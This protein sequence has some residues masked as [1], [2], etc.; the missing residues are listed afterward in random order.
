MAYALLILPLSLSELYHYRLP[1]E[2]D[3]SRVRP[4]MRVVAPLGPKRFYTAVVHSLVDSL[5]EGIQPSRLKEIESVLDES[6]LLSQE[7]LSMWDWLATYYQCSLGQVMR[8]ALPSGLI[9]ESET[10]VMLREDYVA[11]GELAELDMRLLDLLA[12]EPMKQLTMSKVRQR[13]GRGFSKAFER[14]I[15]LGAIYTEEHLRRGYQPR[16]AAYITL[17]PEYRSE[18]ALAEVELR[19]RRAPKQ[20]ELLHEFVYQI[21]EEQQGLSGAI[22]RALFSKGSSG[23]TALLSALVRRGVLSVEERE[24]TRL[25]I[26]SDP[27]ELPPTPIAPL[28]AFSKPVALLYTRRGESREEYI[29][30]QIKRV[31]DASLQVLLLTPSATTLPESSAWLRRVAHV[32][33]GRLW[34]YHP[35]EPEHRRA[36]LYLRLASSSE[37]CVVYGSRAA[38][39]LPL[40]RLGLIIVDEEQEYL[41]KQQHTAPLYNARDVALWLGANRGVQVLLASE[42]PSAEALFNAHRGKSELITLGDD[43]PAVTQ[44]PLEVVDLEREYSMGRL[45]YGRSISYTLQEQIDLTLA[46]GERVLLLQNRRGYA[47]YTECQVCQVRITCPRCAV[48]LPYHSVKRLM[49]C[50]YC[51]YEQ[52]LPE[53]CP[54]C[55]ESEVE[56]YNRRVR[57]LRLV[58]Y[59][60]ERVAEEAE[61]LWQEARVV[62]MDSDSLQTRRSREE[63]HARLLS[64]DVD[65]LVGTPLIK[66]QPVWD[67]IGLVA[68]VNLESILGFPDFR[69][70][71]RAY[72]LLHQLRLNLG[73]RS[74]S[75]RLVIQTRTPEQPFIDS[76]RRGSYGAFIMKELKER[77]LTR[78]APFYRITYIRLRAYDEGVVERI[79]QSLVRLLRQHLLEERI[80]DVQ[81]PSVVKVDNHY[82]RQIVCRR[83][84]SEGYKRER[85][86]FSEALAMLR[87]SEPESSRVRILFDVDPL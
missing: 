7:M 51:G 47:P 43:P 78:F 71:E 14:L 52:A 2:V 86:V 30:G 64:G 53:A 44:M 40:S 16:R 55:G 79:A 70:G 63:L 27:N 9:P 8:S 60:V 23:R 58:G 66:A 84:F 25:A 10:L 22:R 6:P 26:S 87:A 39:F 29:L 80:S 45:P 33:S 42:T 24:L 41:Y 54:H 35:L 50:H 15:A 12:A 73:E 77:E 76:L 83:P 5:P 37:P 61:E 67:D 28:P 48:S 21:Q 85:S 31:L 38:V 81:M 75:A 65:I 74:P 19:L 32:A 68:V 36:E 1:R 18:E 17:A 46:R 69:A 4:G 82:L 62:R 72:Q 59:G 11:E 34:G 20:L 56:R 3:P 13:L 57:A 49:R